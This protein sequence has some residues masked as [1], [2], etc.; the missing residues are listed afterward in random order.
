MNDYLCEGHFSHMVPLWKPQPHS[1]V[2]AQLYHDEHG[3]HDPRS[4]SIKIHSQH[5]LG[6]RPSLPFEVSL[7]FFLLTFV[8]LV[9]WAVLNP[10]F[11][12][13]CNGSFPEGQP[14][15]YPQFA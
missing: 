9:E 1:S 12:P 13:L 14:T 15:V 7:F 4:D 2:W 3:E 11:A 5:V 10:F 6:I 8:P